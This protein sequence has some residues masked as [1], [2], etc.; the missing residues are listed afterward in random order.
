MAIAIRRPNPI[1]R[2]LLLLLIAS[3]TALGALFGAV[4]PA[5]ACSC[6]MTTSAKEW[7]TPEQAVFT[8]TAGGRD[9]R[10]VEVRVDRWLWG[11]GAAPTVWLSKDSFGDGAAC[12]TTPP[13]PGSRWLWVAS[14]REN[15]ADFGTGLCSPAGNL[16]TPEGQAM[17][18]EALAVFPAIAPPPAAGETTVPVEPDTTNETGRQARDRAT[19][20]ILGGLLAGSLALF[21]LVLLVGRRSVRREDERR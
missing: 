19:V 4:R 1:R 17:L 18:K 21:G 3:V 8:G 14:R 6:A 2:A 20:T 5:A 7:A 10:G 16:D 11:A 13:D 9:D 12:G 15:I